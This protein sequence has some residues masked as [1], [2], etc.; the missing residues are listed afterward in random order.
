MLPRTIV[1]C[2]ALAGITTGTA[3]AGKTIYLNRDGG[4]YVRGEDNPATNT[5]SIISSDIQLD[6][7]NVSESDWQAT[8]SCVRELLGDFD[9][10]IV[11]EEPSS[12]DHLEVLITGSPPTA[13]GL[14]ANIW[15]ISHNLCEPVD[16]G[17]NMIFPIATPREDPRFQCELVAQGIGFVAGLSNGLDQADL[18]SWMGDPPRSFKDENVTCGYE[19]PQECRCGGSTQNS[20]QRMLEVFGPSQTAGGLAFVEPQDGQTVDS[21][22]DVRA[23]GAGTLKVFLDDQEKGSMQANGSL[24]L[25]DVAPGSHS[26]TI[27]DEASESATIEIVVAGANGTGPSSGQVSSGCQTGGASSGLLSLLALVF[28]LGARRRTL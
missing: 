12:P 15:A 25:S 6:K 3:H 7:W 18:M 9:L 22:F 1:I 16:R 14:P 24:R 10:Q 27:E 13:I 17:I 19:E 8:V 4:F 23:N 5:S 21:S 26:L 2:L 11:E 28:A 20:Y